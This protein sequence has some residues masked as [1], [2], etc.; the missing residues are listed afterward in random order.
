MDDATAAVPGHRAARTAFATPVAAS[1]V[2][3]SLA[4]PVED[5][6]RFVG[7]E[8]A[9]AEFDGG[10]AL[11]TDRDPSAAL[12]A[13]KQAFVLTETARDGPSV[14]QGKHRDRAQESDPVG[15]KNFASVSLMGSE[16][17]S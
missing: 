12:E 6:R 11:A 9:I 1:P 10:Q 14:M 7:G 2:S 5:A 13:Y 16:T 4:A 8:G 15:L 3:W 17:F